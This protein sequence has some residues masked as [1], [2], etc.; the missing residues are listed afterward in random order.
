VKAP[1]L[2]T[3]ILPKRAG[4]FKESYGGFVRELALYGFRCTESDANGIPVTFTVENF[5]KGKFELIGS[6]KRKGNYGRSRRM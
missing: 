2:L 4:I 5:E 6:V 1:H 3:T